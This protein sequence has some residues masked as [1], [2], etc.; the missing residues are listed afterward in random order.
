MAR[1]RYNLLEAV[2]AADLDDSSEE[3]TIASA[4][5]E[6]GVD[7]PTVS[8]GDTLT[9]RIDQE[10]MHV[11]DYTEG[12]TTLFA[13]R[14][15]E[16]TV[17]AEHFAGAIIKHVPTKEDFNDD[18]GGGGSIVFTVATVN[19]DYPSP[20]EMVT[21][22]DFLCTGENDEDV[23]NI[24]ISLAEEKSVEIEVAPGSYIFDGPV[25]VDGVAVHIRAI[26]PGDWVKTSYT[27]FNRQGIGN[28]YMFELVYDESLFLE[29]IFVYDNADNANTY[30]LIG[31]PGG[32]TPYVQLDGCAVYNWQTGGTLVD[33]SGS[34]AGTLRARNCD[35][36][37]ST[38]LTYGDLSHI[39]MEDCYLW[40]DTVFDHPVAAGFT[41]LKLFN[42]MIDDRMF[43]NGGSSS[44]ANVLITNCRIRGEINLEN[45]DS[46]RI[47]D[48][49][50]MGSGGKLLSL[51]DCVDGVVSNNSRS[52]ADES[53]VPQ[54]GFVFTDC[55][56][57]VVSGNLIKNVGTGLDDTY[58]GISL[59]NSSN[60]AVINNVIKSHESNKLL[61]GIY[62]A[63][64]C[65]N[66]LVEGNDLLDSCKTNGNEIMDEASDT[67]GW[68]THELAFVEGAVT[69]AGGTK[70]NRFDRPAVLG[71]TLLDIDTAPTGQSLIVDVNKNG[72]TIYTT[73]ASRPTVAASDNDG[74]S[75]DLPDV[76]Y[77]DVGD[78]LTADVDQIGSGTAGSDLVVLQR[79][80][81]I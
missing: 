22:A 37:S 80:M 45:F 79:Y 71:T 11:Y 39:E 28:F 64:D 58:F 57:L 72:T 12:A 52:F 14:G 23:F 55:S 31:R 32:D 76:K 53:E 60:I 4:L 27:S 8:G 47:T 59:V 40:A 29:N 41:T 51:V 36:E 65:T 15:M 67:R 44:G 54:D 30:A 1:L 78:Y 10:I 34:N 19:P 81:P 63:N 24:I 62:I 69:V 56:D 9:I 25:F 7:I 74:A 16:N 5:Q 21:R 66:I 77:V 50:W 3:I 35:L 13:Y 70:R 17:A 2:L 20:D 38:S 26:S 18:S 6:G 49:A 43:F 68:L 75:S 46:T 42:C 61:H 48:N 73:Q 33:F